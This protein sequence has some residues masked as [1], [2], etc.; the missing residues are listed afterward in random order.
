MIRNQLLSLLLLAAL[1]PAG[2]TAQTA[3]T[4]A[5]N[6]SERLLRMTA[7]DYFR[8][9][10]PP[11]HVLMENARA[12]SPQVNVYA[13]TKELEE[14]ELKTVRRSWLKYFKLNAGYSYGSTDVTSQQYF[15]NQYPVIQNVTGQEQSWW[16]VGANVSF[17][18]DEIF[19]HRNRV[20]QQK[21]KIESIQY[22]VDRWYDDICLKIIDSY[23]AAVQYLSLLESASAAMVM[24]QAQYE[25]SK[26]DF[27]NGKIDAQT[28]SRQKSI[29][30]TAMREYEQTR[31]ALN[32]ALLE[33][34]VLS[35]T[36]II[37]P[38]DQFI[39]P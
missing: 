21:K 14:R 10:L 35:K 27:I 36:P 38:A 5:L 30:N 7:D 18:L 16:N 13:A 22:E 9:Q 25:F 12:H 37:T 2:A 11:L 31:A 1:L 33:L 23:T 17:P 39:V 24:A 19:N 20:K 29:E 4:T 28:L 8:V 15:N 26:T 6:Q 3:D 34:E 32:K